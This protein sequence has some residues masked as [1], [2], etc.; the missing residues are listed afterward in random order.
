MLNSIFVYTD[1]GMRIFDITVMI[2][3]IPKQ[4]NHSDPILPFCL[5]TH[6]LYTPLCLMTP[7]S[8]SASYCGILVYGQAWEE[9]SCHL[10]LGHVAC[11]IGGSQKARAIMLLAWS[12]WFHLIRQFKTCGSMALT[13]SALWHMTIG[14]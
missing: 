3:M 10:A 8:L 5:S 4:D 1:P 12:G 9:G 14:P 2:K 6:F 11:D 13:P 7:I